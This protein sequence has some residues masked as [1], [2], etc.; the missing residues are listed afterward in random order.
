MSQLCPCGSALE[1]SSC[2]QRYLSG[3]ELAPARHSLCAPV[4]A[5]SS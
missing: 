4:I 5:R 1:Y 2:C 3:A